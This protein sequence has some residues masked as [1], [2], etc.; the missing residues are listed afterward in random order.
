MV[1]KILVNNIGNL[2]FQVKK[3]PIHTADL[4]K[5]KKMLVVQI[6]V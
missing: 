5:K 1:A 2:N 3:N 4:K 6:F